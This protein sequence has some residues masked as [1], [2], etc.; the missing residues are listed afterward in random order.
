MQAT[1][2]GGAALAPCAPA[3]K[4]QASDVEGGGV[5]R[6]DAVDQQLG[7]HRQADAESRKLLRVAQT[8]TRRAKSMWTESGGEARIKGWQFIHS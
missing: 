4:A 2:R 7:L 3:A 8:G 1:K 6:Q 5:K